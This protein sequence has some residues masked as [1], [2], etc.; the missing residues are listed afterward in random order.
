MRGDGRIRIDE[1][2]L[3]GIELIILELLISLRPVF[4]Q[5]YFFVSNF[6]VDYIGFMRDV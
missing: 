6:W 1:N 4:L 2:S 3:I 5:F